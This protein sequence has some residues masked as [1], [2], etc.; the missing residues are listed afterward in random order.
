MR[1]AEQAYGAS[2][3]AARQQE[4]GVLKH[5]GVEVEYWKNKYS[6]SFWKI[7]QISIFQSHPKANIHIPQYTQIKYSF[8]NICS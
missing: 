8:A 2:I 4:K 7:L 1:P 6:Y 3:Y 5:S